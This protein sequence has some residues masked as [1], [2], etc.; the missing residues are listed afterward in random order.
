[1]DVGRGVDGRARERARGAEVD[2]DGAGQAD[3]RQHGAGVAGGVLEGRVAEDAGD[4][5][6]AEARVVGGQED[7]EG[8]L[9]LLVWRG[10][11]A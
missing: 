10:G 5:E 3:G 2:G 11:E 7:G 4:A 8:V 6:E 9:G 1:M